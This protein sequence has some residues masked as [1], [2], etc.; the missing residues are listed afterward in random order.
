[1]EIA[2]ARTELRAFRFDDAKTIIGLS[3]LFNQLD[4]AK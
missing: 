1:M 2:Q 3:A 4:S